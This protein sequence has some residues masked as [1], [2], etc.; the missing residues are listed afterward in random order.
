[1]LVYITTAPKAVPTAASEDMWVSPLTG[2]KIAPDKIQEHVRIGNLFVL[3]LYQLHKVFYIAL[4][5]LKYCIILSQ[6]I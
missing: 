2:E 3:N 1:M 5:E 6:R 4:C